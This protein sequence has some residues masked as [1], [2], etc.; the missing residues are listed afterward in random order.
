[1]WGRKTC[2]LMASMCAAYS[3]VLAKRG[4]VVTQIRCFT[5]DGEARALIRA[6]DGQAWVIRIDLLCG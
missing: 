2:N 5:V 4:N 6:A 1:M 3:Q